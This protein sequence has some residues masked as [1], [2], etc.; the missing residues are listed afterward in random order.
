MVRAVVDTS[1]LIRRERG[2][3]VALPAETAVS[4]ISLA[5]LGLGVL[6]TAD[7]AERAIR[8]ATLT[9]VEREFEAIPVDRRVA[10]R[11]AELVAE[12]RRL[13][14]RPKAMDALIAATALA[15][16]VPIV[17]SDAA[18]AALPLISAIR[19]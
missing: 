7:P 11:Y 19:V 9:R 16:D 1:V 18:L 15:H 10:E 5:E 8:L 17:T 2:A 13:G 12:A 3:T 14:R 6:L 4:A